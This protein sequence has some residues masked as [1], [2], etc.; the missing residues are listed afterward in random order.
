MRKDIFHDRERA[1]EAAY[2]SQQDTKLLQKLREK[3]RL[4]EIARALADKL[5]VDNPALLERIAALGV[6]VDTGAAF[7]L[8]P[9][10]EI[11]WADGSVS[12]A[13]RDAVF[14]LAG[15]RGIAPDSP[16]MRQIEQW[17]S[18]RPPD[19]LFRAALD[20]IKVGLSVLP[21]DEAEQRINTMIQAC[22][23]VAQ[24]AG[25]LR[26]LMNLPGRVSDEE[27]SV[28]REISTRLNAGT[29]P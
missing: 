13:E 8:A 1:E 27:Q 28:L 25:G 7:L 12:A 15:E 17:L 24:S 3:A 10:V 18:Q 11:A 29:S 9:L 14:R 21:R 22:E 6:S 26:K 5:K 16:E 4:G 19:T 2:F 23:L 20:A